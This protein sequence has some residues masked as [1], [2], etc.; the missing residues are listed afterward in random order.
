MIGI[1]QSQFL[2]WLPFF[3]KMFMSDVFVVLDDVQFQK[4]GVQNRN[5]IKTPQGSLWLTI[6][7]HHSLDTPLN[8][9]EVAGAEIYSKIQKTLEMNYRK[10]RFFEPV[11]SRLRMVFEKRHSLLHLLNMDLLN[12]VLDLLGRTVDVRLSSSMNVNEKKEDLVI[13]LI[14]KNGGTSYASGHGGLEYMH[15]NRFRNEG[16]EVS[17]CDFTYE[18]Y[19]QLW[20]RGLGFIPDLS[21]IDLLFNNLDN[22]SSYILSHGTIQKM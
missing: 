9:V 18:T 13:A 1:H 12:V 2:P 15:L 14:K 7:V 11:Y 8:S 10:S 20:A 4:N 21:V 3:Y 16:I 5:M 17:V 19:P 6:P 22:A